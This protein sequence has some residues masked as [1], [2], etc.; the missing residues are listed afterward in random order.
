MY[1]A[2]RSL[3]LECS[4]FI[5]EPADA[6]LRL[7]LPRVLYRQCRFCFAKETIA[8]SYRVWGIGDTQLHILPEEAVTEIFAV[9][10]NVTGKGCEEK[11]IEG[12]VL[13][14]TAQPGQTGDLFLTGWTAALLRYAEI[15]LRLVVNGSVSEALRQKLKGWETIWNMPGLF[16]V[17]ETT[18]GWMRWAASSQAVVHTN[19]QGR[20]MIRL[21][22]ARALGCRLITVPGAKGH[23][24][25]DYPQLEISESKH[26][27]ALAAVL[28]PLVEK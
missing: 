10:G 17:D 22:A 28:M 7:T 25:D 15:Q 6:R 12:A 14:T 9:D 16:L 8:R 23:I 11:D 19:E 2:G 1:L 3:K 21:H 18:A 4:Y 13:L 27:K 20:N 5:T 24:P 26:P